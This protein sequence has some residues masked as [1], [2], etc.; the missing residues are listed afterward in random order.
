[1]KKLDKLLKLVESSSSSDEKDFVSLND[2]SSKNLVGLGGYKTSNTSCS[3][4]NSS[5]GNN[6][7]SGSTNGSCSNGSCLDEDEEL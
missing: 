5:C 4:T 2:L 6:S 3:G 7:C 1:M